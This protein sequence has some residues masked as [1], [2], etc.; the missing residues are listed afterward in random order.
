M[1]LHATCIS[2]DQQGVLLTGPP[3]SGKSNLALRLIDEGAELIADDQTELH[4]EKD[5]LIATAPDS[6][7]GLFEIR[8]VG[9]IRMPCASNARIAL[10]IDL[11]PTGEKLDR[12]PE[13]ESISLLDHPVRRLR[14]PSFAA[15]TPA[16]IR[17][18]L[19]YPFASEK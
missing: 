11:A 10:Y 12:L 17:A 7:K 19:R 16:K 1:L 14:L 4:I 18:A 5:A 2:I 6:I 15:S 13:D 3:G 9:L 8:H